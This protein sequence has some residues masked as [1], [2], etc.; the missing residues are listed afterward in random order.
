MNQMNINERFLASQR[1][2]LFCRVEDGAKQILNRRIG[3]FWFISVHLV[4][5]D[6]YLEQIFIKL[7]NLM[8]LCELTYCLRLSFSM[9]QKGNRVDE[10]GAL[11]LSSS[12]FIRFIKNGGLE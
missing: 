1:I 4:H 12:S 5:Q 3:R 11:T 9:Y 2:N 8:N 10:P 7:M 6:R